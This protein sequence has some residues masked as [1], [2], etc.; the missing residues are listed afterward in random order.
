[1]KNSYPCPHFQILNTYSFIMKNKLGF[2]NL[3][4]QNW[5]Y[6]IKNINCLLVLRCEKKEKNKSS[7]LV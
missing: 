6:L 2:F 1:M 4:K 5:I 3:E 7:K